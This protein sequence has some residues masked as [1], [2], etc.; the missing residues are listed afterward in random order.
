MTDWVN[1]EKFKEEAFLFL[2]KFGLNGLRSY[3]RK[4]GLRAATKLKKKE[5]IL[6]TIAERKKP[7]LRIVA[8]R[9]KT[10]LFHPN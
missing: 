4:V 6:Q 10:N 3:G 1:V 2:N 5:V 9:E 7:L 8:R